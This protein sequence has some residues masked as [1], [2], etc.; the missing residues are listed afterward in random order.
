MEE[1]KV[2][3]ID[4][5]GFELAQRTA[6]VL[7]KS[8]LVP[9]QFKNNLPNCII[10]INMASRIGADPLMVMQ[11]M[12]IV[13]GKPSWSS[14][15]LIAAINSCGKFK[16][17]LRFETNGECEQKQCIAWTIDLTGERL[18]SPAITI[19]M[20]KDEGWL[21]KAGSK[22]KTM[23]ELMLRYRAAAFF[24][25]LYCPEITMGM[26]TVE[27]IQDAVIIKDPSEEENNRILNFIEKATS[28][29]Q[30][31]EVEPHL[32]NETQKQKYDEK[33]NQI[34]GKLSL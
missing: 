1:T 4:K 8:D 9:Q 33:L 27:E 7:S 25:R 12:Y 2:S 20:A 34:Q 13:H 29:D 24:S 10:A 5:E 3:L 11:N 32:T 17:P 28:V 19:Q 30:L 31:K 6:T 23:P 16:A 22:W 18:E 26:H 14:T 15:F 21:N